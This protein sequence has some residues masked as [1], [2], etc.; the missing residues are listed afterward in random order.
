MTIQRYCNVFPRVITTCIS[1]VCCRLILLFFTRCVC[2][3]KLWKYIENQPSMKACEHQMQW[4]TATGSSCFI[5]CAIGAAYC[6]GMN[7]Y[8]LYSEAD[9]YTHANM[10]SFVNKLYTALKGCCILGL[11]VQMPVLQRVM[12]SFYTCLCM[13]EYVCACVCVPRLK[14]INFMQSQFF[15]KMIR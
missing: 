12:M 3:I 4:I 11:M 1:C 6:R 13:C 2:R 8:T 10:P 7:I 15:L 14:C 9:I 5:A